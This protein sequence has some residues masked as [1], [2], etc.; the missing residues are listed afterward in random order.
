MQNTVTTPALSSATA[1]TATA[2]SV[3]TV[4]LNDNAT[5]SAAQATVNVRHYFEQL[6]AEREAWEINA[7]RT[8]NEQLYALL[9]KCYSTY[10]AMTS[11]SEEADALRSGLKDYINTKGLKFN[12]GT[13]T[14]VKIVKCIFGNDRR[15]ISAYGIVLRAALAQ[16]ISVLDIPAFIRSNGGVEE[17]R[18]AKAPNAM[19]VKQKA[20]AA[21]EAVLAESMGVFVSN[22]LSSKLDAGNIGKSVVLIGTWQ[23]D[24]S[25]VVRSVVQ[26]DTAVNA[27]LASYYSANKAAVLEQ[28]KQQEAANDAQVAQDAINAAVS[29][30]VING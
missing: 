20:S 25:V 13:H 29:S 27:A 1:I 7:F 12:A 18:L 30:A 14:L 3:S 21:A 10:A 24:G 11:D 2:Q 9:Q 28:S 26:N 4:V 16:R 15:R 22:A 19:T 17:I 23:A 8:S 5:I 6:T